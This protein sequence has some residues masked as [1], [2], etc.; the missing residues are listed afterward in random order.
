MTEEEEEEKEKDLPEMW[1]CAV[2][3]QSYPG[4]VATCVRSMDRSIGSN[5]HEPYVGGG[6]APEPCTHVR[7]GN[8]R[9]PLLSCDGSDWDGSAYQSTL[10][11]VR[12]SRFAP[13][14]VKW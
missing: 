7:S 3:L 1:W 2:R 11:P 13:I 14:R 12:A 4:L 6:D 10:G 5:A 8:L 9:F